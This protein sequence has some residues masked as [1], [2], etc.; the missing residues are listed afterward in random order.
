MVML[1]RLV[2]LANTKLVRLVIP[3]PRVILVRLKHDWKALGPMLVTLLGMVTLVRLEQ[4]MKQPLP[5]L[6]TLP[7][8]VTLVKAA[9]ANASLPMLVTGRPLM[10]PGMRMAAPPGPV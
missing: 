9:P 6:V 1:V 2:Q 8:I 7:G 5:R 4:L 3:V 10:A